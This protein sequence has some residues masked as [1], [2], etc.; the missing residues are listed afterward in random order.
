M[1]EFGG[2]SQFDSP[3]EL[4]TKIGPWELTK[5]RFDQPEDITVWEQGFGEAELIV[6][7]TAMEV[8]YG[9][10]RRHTAVRYREIGAQG[11]EIV[12]DVGRT[13]AFEIAVN[14]LR[15]VGEPLSECSQLRSTLETIHGIG[16]A[17]S[18]QLILLGITSTDDLADHI[19]ADAPIINHH[20]A[21]AVDTI[22]TS[23]IRDAVGGGANTAGDK[24]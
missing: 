4:P 3:P 11:V 8:H 20:H 15:T 13:S 7:Q 14:A 17:K 22:L 16:P 18:R 24:P 2:D 9:T 5:R 1:D 6:E 10:T 23:S 19:A 12:D 21:Q